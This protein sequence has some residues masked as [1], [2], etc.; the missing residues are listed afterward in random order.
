MLG[1]ILYDPK[2]MESA[3]GTIPGMGLLDIEVEFSPE[4][5]RT[6]G[7]YVPTE[8]N[9]FRDAMQAARYIVD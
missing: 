4:E 1:R 3:L 2:R 5:T 8:A 6:N 7:V 9:P